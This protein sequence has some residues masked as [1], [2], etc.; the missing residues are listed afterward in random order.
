M[1]KGGRGGGEGGGR[2]VGTPGRE[3]ESEKE[4]PGLEAEVDMHV[5]GGHADEDQARED[6]AHQGRQRP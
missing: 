3:R 4:H 1:R 5:E 2:R 6:V